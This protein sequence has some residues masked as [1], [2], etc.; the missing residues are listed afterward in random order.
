MDF[1]N[2]LMLMQTDIYRYLMGDE[3]FSGLLSEVSYGAQGVCVRKDT[4]FLIIHAISETL[5]YE[6][7]VFGG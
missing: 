5:G 6:R 4:A 1:Y 3:D 7:V 2:N